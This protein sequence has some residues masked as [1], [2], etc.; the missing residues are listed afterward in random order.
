MT[1]FLT[2]DDVVSLNR[3]LNRLS[4][5]GAPILSNSNVT[6]IVDRAKSYKSLYETA[7]YYMYAINTLHPFFGA[8]KRTGF[9]AAQLF[10]EMN[11][12]KAKLSNKRVVQLSMEIRSQQV[13]YEKLK[14]IFKD[15]ISPL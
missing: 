8:N 9:V 4:G 2:Y 7:A 15:S 11:G 14:Y 10:L 1:Y 13:D 6:L 12:Y 5:K 3:G